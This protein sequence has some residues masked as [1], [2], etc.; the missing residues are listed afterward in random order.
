MP[1]SR[2]SS[3][4]RGVVFSLAFIVDFTKLID[5]LIPFNEEDRPRLP[6]GTG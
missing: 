6:M 5:V 4:S 2:N 1:S 3:A